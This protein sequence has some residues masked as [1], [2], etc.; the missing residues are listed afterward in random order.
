MMC[1]WGRELNKNM[2]V[3]PPAFVN[4]VLLE[5]NQTHLFTYYLELMHPLWH[6]D[7]R[8]E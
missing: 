1:L 5:H 2:A 8:I 6:Y 3:Y 7:R 4:E